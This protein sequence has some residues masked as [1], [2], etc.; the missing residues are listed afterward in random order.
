VAVVAFAA[1]T[2]CLTAAI[3]APSNTFADCADCP[4]M[5]RIPPGQFTMGS[6]AN[7]LFRGAE[8][9]HR[10][11]IVSPFA[12]SAYEITFAQWDACVAHG[13]CR[14]YRPDDQGW[15]RG[16]HPVIGV[17]WNDAKAYVA[18]LSKTTGKPYRL[19][20]ESEWEYA[21]RAATT[22]AFSFGATIS[23][24]QANYDGSTAYGTGPK[25]VNRAKTLPVGSFPPNAFGLY[26]MHGN[27]WEWTED[28]WS[29]EYTNTT[30]A[31]GAAFVQ[32]MCAGHVLRGGSWEDHPADL[33]SAAR[34]G[35]ASD[36]QSWSDGFRVA[37]SLR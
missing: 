24:A 33:R 23:T 4:L 28:C 32:P 7:E 29:D 2:A 22:T 3:A 21:A 5:V 27:V 12:L 37:L 34:V 6:P 36:D 26:D 1:A 13:G 10:V 30:P 19:A 18:W 8:K 9:Q 31:N 16:K 15:G 20:S 25:G 11:T 35:G 17:S 14:G